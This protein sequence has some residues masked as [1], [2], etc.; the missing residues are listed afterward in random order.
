MDPEAEGPSLGPRLQIIAGKGGVGR[1]T[2]AAALALAAAAEGRRVLAVDAINDGGLRYAL[3]DA[4]AIP[5]NLQVVELDT[6]TAL[7]EYLKVYFKFPVPASRLGPV[8]RIFEYVATAAPGV[9]EIL[10]IG[11]IGY[12]TR[13]GDFD[14]VVVDAPA[15][16]HVVELL[17]APENLKRLISLGPLV[18]QTAWLSEMLRDPERTGVWLTTTPEELPVSESLELLQ[19]ITEETGVTVLGAVLNRV[20]PLA[21]QDPASAVAEESASAG[22]R[23]ALQMV[24]EQAAASKAERTR[25]LEAFD[26]ALPDGQMI[27]IAESEDPLSA[28]MRV[29]SQVFR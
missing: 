2:V 17:A 1:S 8:A 12:D 5:T 20:P 14:L 13:S 15:T 3:G 27:E 10:T 7:D 26:A 18:E 29:W 21:R 9:T 16:G 11:K 22:L 23:L 28:S 4:D 24:T 19:R 6:V 25:F